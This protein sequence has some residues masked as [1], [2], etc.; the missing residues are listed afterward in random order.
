MRFQSQLVSS[1][2]I[3]NWSETSS[4]RSGVMLE[5]ILKLHN[6]I[7]SLQAEEKESIATWIDF[8]THP[9]RGAWVRELQ[10]VWCHC[11]T[12]A[13]YL[14]VYSILNSI[15]LSVTSAVNECIQNCKELFR[16]NLTIWWM[17]DISRRRSWAANKKKPIWAFLKSRQIFSHLVFGV[18]SK[19]AWYLHL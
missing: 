19:F 4:E 13:S 17:D 5:T 11:S 7:H 12:S 10:I 18:D 16:L 3:K 9:S 14:H 2:I 15:T 6:C 8:N 1:L